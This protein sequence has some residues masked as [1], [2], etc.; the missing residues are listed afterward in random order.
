MNIS[1][2]LYKVF[3]YVCEFKSITKAANFLYVSQPA[4]TKQIKKLESHI[5]RTLITRKLNG[6]EL[7]HEGAK[8]YNDIKTPVEKLIKAENSFKDKDYE[9]EIR[10]IAGYSTIK[11]IL[12]ST[13]SNFHMKHP[14]I[15][16]EVEAYP[17]H[18]AIQR[19][20]EGRADLI[21]LNMKDSTDNL[22]DLIV[23][24]CYDMHHIFV[25]HKDLKDKI[26]DKINV[27]DLNNYPVI[28]KTKN[29]L[30]RRCI[31][32]Y[33]NEAGLHFIPKYELSNNWLI[34]EYVNMKLGMGLVTKEFVLED[35]RSGKFIEIKVDKPL[36]QRGVSYACRKNAPNY[37]L[38]K[39]FINELNKNMEKATK[40]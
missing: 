28:C 6:I 11:K 40:L 36:S 39:E 15:K 22:T 26:P 23:K 18:E 10:I 32:G 4:I 37:K 38:L 33:Y 7:T 27:L 20:R 3:Y 1:F 25:V 17:Y 2:D 19:L 21:F 5:G 8:L 34:E 35:L 9:S 24:K 13:L 30:S 16:F 14:N 12:L 31:D 29:S